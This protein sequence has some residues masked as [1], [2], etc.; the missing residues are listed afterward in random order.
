MIGGDFLQSL[1]NMTMWIG[2]WVLPTLAA[3][4]LCIAIYNYANGRQS[5]RYVMG[6]LLCLM[7]PGCALLVQHFVITPPL[8][9]GADVVSGSLMNAVSYLGNV[10]M[11]I[12]AV[13]CVIRGV[14][15]LG[16]PVER[17]HARMDVVK[18]F[19]AALLSLMVSGLLRLLE[20]FVL[21]ATQLSPGSTSMIVI[22]VIGASRCLSA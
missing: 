1:E 9:S 19:G 6:A 15:D 3:L 21:G 16:A 17:F 2:Y 20:H 10:I 18:H 14:I 4:S 13:V 8:N 7:G 11:P 5:G 12:F 22:H